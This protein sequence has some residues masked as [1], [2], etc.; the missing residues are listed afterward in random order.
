MAHLSI[1]MLG[2]FQVSL[3]GEP[4]SGFASDKVRALLAYLALSPDRP[5]RREALAGLLWPEFPERSARSSL[6][7][8][9]AN[10][11]QV[12]GDGAASPPF[13]HSTRQTIQFNGQSDYWLDADA[14]E[15][16]LALLPSMS[17]QLEQA[18]SLVQGPFLDGFTLADAAPFEEWLLLRREYFC[19][20]VV[21]ALDRLAAIH[22][23]HGAFELALAHAR[24]RVELEPWQE[25]GQRQLMR[26][27]ARSGQ[28]CQA[29]DRYEKLCRSL[30]EELGAE[31]LAETRALCEDI[32][33]GASASRTVDSLLENIGIAKQYDSGDIVDLSR[34]ENIAEF[35][36]SVAEYG[37]SLPAGGLPGFMNEISLA[38][39][40]DEYEGEESGKIALMTL[41]CAKGLEFN[42][43]FVAGL[44]EGMLPFVR[45]GEYAPS[46]IEEERRLLYVGM[47]RAKER[48]ILTFAISRKR[49]GVRQSGP[50]RF[51]YEITSGEDRFQSTTE[52]AADRTIEASSS[53]NSGSIY[54]SRGNLIRHPRYG[55]GLVRKAVRKGSEWQITVDFG[56]D[57]PKTLVTG[58][59]PV[60]ILKIKGS[61]TDL[62]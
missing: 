15:D 56:F 23:G 2:P 41:H 54:Y 51:I 1:R 42:T 32:L 28:R 60:P 37:N 34:L 38:T 13:L 6:R 24:R 22:E 59:V 61:M 3:D 40:V 57:E 4:V 52:T 46:D 29:L 44:E 27:L 14:F 62:D 48:L 21:E 33:S 36:K 58:Y 53:T 47:T 45:P 31:P 25:E 12:I 55:K 16:L 5:H 18:V 26:L 17:V 8:A 35:R 49:A 10:L 43:V 9:L 50:S 7:N 30:Q 39:T 19:R 11:R 20:R